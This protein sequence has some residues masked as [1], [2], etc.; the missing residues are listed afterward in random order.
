MEERRPSS[1]HAVGDPGGPVMA[2]AGAT[3]AG[4][5]AGGKHNGLVAT[6]I[7]ASNTVVW[8][9]AEAMEDDVP[10]AYRIASTS[11][12]RAGDGCGAADDG[13]A[14]G[15]RECKEDIPLVARLNKLQPVASGST[16]AAP[17]VRATS[18]DERKAAECRPPADVVQPL[19]ADRDRHGGVGD[20]D[21]HD[22]ID[23]DDDDD[24]VPLIQRVAREHPSPSAPPTKKTKQQMSGEK[25][26]KRNLSGSAER[27]AVAA[28]APAPAAKSKGN[29]VQ[30]AGKRS[31]EH[32]S[33]T[34]EPKKAKTEEPQQYK[35]WT[36][37]AVSV[38][39]GA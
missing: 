26:K 27:R 7:A 1:V 32:G 15:D 19:A 14:R 18:P 2:D 37:R 3:H 13:R 4:G 34:K 20:A 31:G 35:W 6:T 38:R 25:A 9:K 30:M 24:N 21:G 33:V 29:G 36:V 22:D 23:D 16:G 10:L 17:S 11:A 8:T 12:A 39:S 5:A 28:P